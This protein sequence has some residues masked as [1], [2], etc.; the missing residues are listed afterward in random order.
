[1]VGRVSAIHG[2]AAGGVVKTDHIAVG[3]RL[4][5]AHVPPHGAENG[6]EVAGVSATRSLKARPGV[7]ARPSHTTVG[8]AI[9]DILADG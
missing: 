8:G 3:R 5:P 2:L 9:H 1:M 6:G 4:A 7:A